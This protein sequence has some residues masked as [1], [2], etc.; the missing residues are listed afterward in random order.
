AAV[1]ERSDMFGLGAILCEIL[2]GSPPHQSGES[3]RI[4][5]R[6]A[7]GNLTDADARLDACGADAELIHLARSCLAGNPADRPPNPPAVAGVVTDYLAGVPQRLRA[8][9]GQKA[10]AE[11]KAKAERRA[12]RR[13][14]VLAASLVGAILVA[15]L[16]WVGDQR[17]R[18]ARLART[19][20]EVTEILGTV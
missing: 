8:A 1:T 18:D 12:R 6:A 15:A 10:A 11:G 4:L 13:I 2:T 9:E 17:A 16:L 3:W 7:E 19:A 5:M 14:V 20:G